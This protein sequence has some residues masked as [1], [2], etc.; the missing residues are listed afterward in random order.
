MKSSDA[1]IVSHRSLLKV[2]A[3]VGLGAVA[4]S[5]IDPLQ[6]ADGQSGG[7]GPGGLW[8]RPDR[9]R[10]F[11]R[12]AVAVSVVLPDD[13]ARYRAGHR[14][15]GHLH[16]QIDPQD[17]LRHRHWRGVRPPETTLRAPP[18][19]VCRRRRVARRHT[20]FVS[21]AGGIRSHPG[22][23]FGDRLQPIYDGLCQLF[24]SLTGDCQP[25]G[26]RYYPADGV[27]GLAL[28]LHCGGGADV[29]CAGA[30]HHPICRRRTAWLW[31]RRWRL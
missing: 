31:R 8:R 3:A 10:G 14:G 13:P 27:K 7:H 21:C 15:L 11:S 20:A 26:V 29:G 16:P 30:A 1:L 28:D 9:G 5:R 18:V 2:A 24:C 12:S 6:L 25:A 17:R 4:L 19:A 23:L 22:R